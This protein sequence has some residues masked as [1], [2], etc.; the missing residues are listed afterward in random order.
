MSE[1]DSPDRPIVIVDDEKAIVD[2]IDTA[3]QL[4]GFTNIRRA[5][6]SGELLP[7]LDES[8]SVLC[9]DLNLP[10]R[11]GVELLPQVLQAHPEVA[12]IVIT[13]V[14]DLDT[15]VQCMKL[16]AYDYLTKPVDRDRLVTTVRHALERSELTNENRRLRDTILQPDSPSP[17]AFS[18]IVT[19]SKRMQG[20]FRYAEAV[21][22][23]SFPVLITGETGVGKELLARAIHD[24]SG[25][26][27][28]FVAVNVAGL[29]DTLFSD[30]MFGHV[31]G[32]YT[33]AVG[34]RE[35]LIKSADRGTL[36]M[37]EVGD[38]SSESQ[39]K[40]LRLIQEA[41]YTPLGED[42]AQKTTARFVFATNRDLVRR[43][44]AG[45]FRHDLYFRLTSHSIAIPPLR[46][47][48]EDIPLL[49][50]YFAATTLKALGR[51]AHE[52]P[53]TVRK[54]LLAGRYPGNVR[55]LEGR[56]ADAVVRL[57][58]GL[59]VAPETDASQK[60]LETYVSAAAVFADGRSLPTIREATDA[61]I[62]EALNRT[63]G[64][65]TAAARMLGLTREALNRR[66]N[67]RP[68]G[69]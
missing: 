26:T 16:G 66:I 13:A 42:K 11:N 12:V 20:V 47:R 63:E 60:G 34:S 30:T 6:S 68:D 41:Q 53:V 45:S 55:E 4:E 54:H 8:P 9:L 27:G 28:G 18:P 17:E 22:K 3:L 50:D 7:I 19:R 69:E 24:V 38:L 57:D 37:D 31:R 1:A 33:G 21:G 67:R 32:A 48:P 25:R 44:A 29:D 58:S 10:E 36:F 56:V 65:Q 52:L 62:E 23:T 64:N 39:V 15:A 59:P 49:V 14:A 51:E 35:G 61:L 5:M 40:L 46:E 2:A 43:V